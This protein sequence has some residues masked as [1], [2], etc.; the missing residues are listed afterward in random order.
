MRSG[1]ALLG[2]IVVLVAACSTQP[3]PVPSST[4]AASSSASG[5]SAAPAPEATVASQF[6]PRWMGIATSALQ[7]WE[8]ST[9]GITRDFQNFG[10]RPVGETELPRRCN[11]CGVDPPTAFMTAYAPGVFD[12]AATRSDQP[13]SVL[14]DGDGFFSPT[15]GTEDAVLTWQYA[16]NAWAT[17]RGRTTTTSELNRMLELARA[18][19]PAEF[20]PIVAPF[21]LANLPATLPLAEV[22]TDHGEYGTTLRFGACG[23]TDRG[24]VPECMTNSEQLAVEVW[25]DAGYQGHIQQHQ[26]VPVQVGGKDGLY[27]AEFGEAAVPLDDGSLAVFDLSAPGDATPSTALVDILATVEWAPDPGNDATW[28][29]I[30]DWVR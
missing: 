27:D 8:E 9:R 28:R 22:Y 5:A 18:L 23:M 19:R 6:D 24:A 3:A 13:V 1:A 14:G 26:T 17:V 30:G 11:G 29:A 15:E 2:A 20:T 16:D 4:P 12:P 7:G 10:F 25:P 21:S